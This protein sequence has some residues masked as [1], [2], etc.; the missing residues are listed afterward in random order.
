MVSNKDDNQSTTFSNL[1][2]TTPSSL[3]PS[4]S[5]SSRP[6][7]YHHKTAPDPSRLAPED[8]LIFSQ[9]RRAARGI[10]DYHRPAT[11]NGGVAG[12]AGGFAARATTAGT[13]ALPDARRKREKAGLE[14]GGV[15]VSGSGT[16]S[17]R[18]RV[19]KKL[20]WVKQSCKKSC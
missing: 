4:A 20:L 3:T 7:L 18:K 9:I 6:H 2:K 15:G 11:E 5:T 10:E 19:W 12:T 13:T 16:G 14:G 1:T 8:A 17:R